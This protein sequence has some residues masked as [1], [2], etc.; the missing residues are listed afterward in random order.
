MSLNRSIFGPQMEFLVTYR[1]L[2][3]PADYTKFQNGFISMGCINDDYLNLVLT[4]YS[5]ISGSQGSNFGPNMKL[6]ATY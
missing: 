1:A 2:V 3:D 6:L 4:L 5:P